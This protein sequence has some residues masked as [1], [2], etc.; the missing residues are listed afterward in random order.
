[1]SGVLTAQK[2][3]RRLVVQDNN[4]SIISWYA[5]QAFVHFLVLFEDAI[6]DNGTLECR[7]RLKAHSAV[8]H[9]RICTE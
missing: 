4:F 7:Q 6:T 5:L 9:G 2:P 8:Y 3:V 1:M